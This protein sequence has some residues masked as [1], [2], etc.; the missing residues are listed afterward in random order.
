MKKFVPICFLLVMI[1]FGACSLNADQEKMLSESTMRFLESR[2]KGALLA[3]VSMHHPGVVRYYKEQGD[4]VF[5]E[6]FSVKA[7]DHFA[8]E[9]LIVETEKKGQEIQVL[10]RTRRVEEF[11][12][13]GEK[14]WEYFVAVSNDNGRSWYYLDYDDYVDKRIAKELDR[15]IS[16][17]E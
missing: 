9:A 12:G 16:L 2:K 10:Y 14:K 6:K 13:G 3:Y 4:S 8:D 15:M 1:L 11:Y 5:T 17:K 7:S